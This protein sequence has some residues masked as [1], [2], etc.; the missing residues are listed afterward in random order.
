MFK[1]T[2]FMDRN[3]NKR[4][5]FKCAEGGFSVQTNGNLPLAHMMGREKVKGNQFALLTEL[6]IHIFNH[7]T[8][9]QMNLLPLPCA[10]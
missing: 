10:R 9:R 6:R 8:H 2:T 3:G 5:R 7:G 4:L 1:I